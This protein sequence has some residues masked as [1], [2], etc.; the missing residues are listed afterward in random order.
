VRLKL[1]ENLGLRIADFFR[2]AGHDVETVAG[3]G[4]SGADDDTV[5]QACIKEKRVLV[6]MD[7]DFSDVVRF[8]PKRCGGIVIFRLPGSFSSGL[9]ERM[10]GDFLEML[11]I[12]EFNSDL[13]IVEPGR[14]RIHQEK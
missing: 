14:I 2:G 10:S 13:W 3:E 5:F 6:T 9:F 4:L 1:D 7:L 8:E 12:A 11:R